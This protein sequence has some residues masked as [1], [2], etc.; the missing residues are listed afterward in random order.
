MRLSE[1]ANAKNNESLAGPSSNEPLDVG[2]LQAYASN[3]HTKQNRYRRTK[4]SGISSDLIPLGIY[5]SQ[6]G[7]A[8]ALKRPEKHRRRKHKDKK[9]STE[10]GLAPVGN[11]NINRTVAIDGQSNE[12]CVF[13]DDVEKSFSS[14]RLNHSPF[15]SRDRPPKL[16]AH[17]YNRLPN[18][19]L[20]RERFSAVAR[21]SRNE[22]ALDSKT[23]EVA[24]GPFNLGISRASEH[25]KPVQKTRPASSSCFIENRMH[26]IEE[27]EVE[28]T[29]I[30]SH[31]IRDDVPLIQQECPKPLES[32][33]ASISDLDSDEQPVVHTPVDIGIVE[34]NPNFS[35]NELEEKGPISLDDFNPETISIEKRLLLTV[36]MSAGVFARLTLR[37]DTRRQKQGAL[38]N[39]CDVIEPAQTREILH[40][41]QKPDDIKLP[42]ST[43]SESNGCD[44]TVSA[45]QDS[46]TIEA[47]TGKSP[48]SVIPKTRKLD[49][50]GTARNDTPMHTEQSDE[51]C[52]LEGT[53]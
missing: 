12:V 7:I 29:G 36:D 53:K 22:K 13:E 43:F 51:T 17:K 19:L 9:S 25:L 11:G 2:R 31:F 20:S 23:Q 34:A 18:K 42:S 50:A 8:E 45:L 5:D 37:N 32:C 4:P 28:S 16:S 30:R 47:L 52:A 27:H 49:R 15:A 14:S 41:Q 3:R 1:S 40:K 6:D 46:I 21:A 44:D 26:S 33:K 35:R 38:L 48:F 39:V 24:D 10:N